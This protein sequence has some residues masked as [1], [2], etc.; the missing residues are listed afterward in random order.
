MMVSKEVLVETMEECAAQ[1][2]SILYCIVRNN[3]DAKID[4]LYNNLKASKQFLYGDSLFRHTDS[5]LSRLKKNETVNEDEKAQIKKLVAQIDLALF[6][7]NISRI[8]EYQTCAN[9]FFQRAVPCFN[10]Y[11]KGEIQLFLTLRLYLL[12]QAMNT[13]RAANTIELINKYFSKDPKTYF[14]GDESSEK[15]SSEK[16][17]GRRQIMMV[18]G[19]ISE[20]L[21]SNVRD[22][23]SK[24]RFGATLITNKFL[25]EFIQYRL[26][27]TFSCEPDREIEEGFPETEDEMKALVDELFNEDFIEEVTAVADDSNTES[28]TLE[29]S[30]SEG[31]DSDLE[32]CSIESD[33][34]SSSSSQATNEK[35]S[36]D[37]PANSPAS[38]E[39]EED[40]LI[41]EEESTAGNTSKTRSNASRHRITDE[42]PGARPVTAQEADFSDDAGVGSSRRSSAASASSNDASGSRRRR[43]S[44]HSSAQNPRKRR[45]TENGSR[46]SS[47]SDSNVDNTPV[48]AEENVEKEAVAPSVSPPAPVFHICDDGKVRKIPPAPKIRGKPQRWTQQEVQ[49]LEEG[50]RIFKRKAW[51]SI[52]DMFSDV[53]GSHTPTQLKEKSKNE[54]RRRQKLGIPLEGFQYYL[55]PQE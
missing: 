41:D 20:F 45:A 44:S 53:L 54:V 51:S 14:F 8:N 11:T 17:A 35:N 3:A 37:I 1:A 6:A 42:Q 48:N 38:R 47:V 34:D 9:A 18:V 4:D 21:C 16:E 49:A 40:E 31:N 43:R 36:T 46:R 5:L 29:S 13:D 28:Y 26:D 10:K 2:A 55:N 15:E 33:S 25:K 22:L 12:R 32:S 7:Y 19:I 27:D 24:V 52:H 39:D 50:L 23:R 30:E